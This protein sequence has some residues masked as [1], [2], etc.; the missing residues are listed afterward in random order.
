MRLFRFRRLMLTTL[1]GYLDICSIMILSA[2]PTGGKM[3][4]RE[5]AIYELGQ[6]V[7]LV[8]THNG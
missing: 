2:T 5:R 7:I 4:C 1:E 6:G 3:G 8:L